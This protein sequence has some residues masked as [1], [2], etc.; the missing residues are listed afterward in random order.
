MAG[1]LVLLPAFFTA[2]IAL[3]GTTP[4]VSRVGSATICGDQNNDIICELQQMKLKIAHMESVLE[5]S[6]ENL[7]AK[8]LHLK[9]QEKL[10]EEM[11]H[12]IHSL[13]TA[14]ISMKGDSSFAEEKINALEEKVQLLWD[15]SRKNN[16]NMHILET[17][18]RDAEKRLEV[19]SSQVE[20]MT[21]IVTEQ[22]I[23]IQ[24][25]E[26]ALLIATRNLK[27][28]KANYRCTFLKLFNNF[29]VHLQKT[30]Q[31]LG[32][33]SFVRESFL[34]SYTS[35]ALHQLKKTISAAKIY[36]HELQG[37]VKQE[38]ERNEFTAVLA[39]K[40]VIFFV[41]SALIIFPI[42]GAWTWLSSCFS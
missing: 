31:V 1:F 20:K 19:V 27:A 2:A 29:C 33:Y 11:K 22:W 13:Q 8:S 24:Q 30:F 38:M 21:D 16:F 14:L 41:A 35:Q 6:V 5:E 18:A 15:A 42:M 34:S 9:E 36:H 12:K 26:Q 40:E 28:Q 17:K 4:P 10:I 25:L 32:Q 39:N 7:N 37:F 3:S 23:Q